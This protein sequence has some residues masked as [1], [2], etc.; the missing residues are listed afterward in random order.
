MENYLETAKNFLEKT[1][2][3]FTIEFVKSGKHFSGDTD[4][5]DIYKFTLKRGSRTYSAEFGNSLNDS[6]LKIKNKGGRI[7]RTYNTSDML[8][9]GILKTVENKF[10]VDGAKFNVTNKQGYKVTQN[11]LSVPTFPNEY[12]VLACLTKYNPGTFENFCDEF[13]YGGSVKAAK[14]YNAV[15]KE[16]AGVCSLWNEDEIEQLM[17]IN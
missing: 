12:D 13:G 2:T 11:E 14:I 6:G 8:K 4:V 5:R 17:E 7:L 16:Y 1:N 3:T 15:C 10:I 9:D